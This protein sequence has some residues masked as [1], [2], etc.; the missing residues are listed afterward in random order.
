[1]PWRRPAPGPYGAEAR[2]LQSSNTPASV[3]REGRPC[4]RVHP[5]DLAALGIDDGASVR[6]GNAR[7]SLVLEARAFAGLQQGV[8]V[9]EGI[10][11]NHAFAEGVGINALISADPGLPNGGA[12][13]HDTAVW[14]RPA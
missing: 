1:M 9:V 7:G 14:A 6:L 12:V 10:W 8:L 5:A 2:R 4:V 13:Y 3:A 11:P